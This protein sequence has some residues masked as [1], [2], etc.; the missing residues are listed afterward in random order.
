[1]Q[2]RAN[3]RPP[4]E[5][6]PIVP[7]APDESAR[8]FAD[9]MAAPLRDARDP[10][11]GT[12]PASPSAPAGAADPAGS[13][14]HSG[15]AD[16][17]R[18]TLSSTAAP[19]DDEPIEVHSRSADL[20]AHPEGLLGQVLGERYELLRL[21]GRGGMGAV[22]LARHVS[23]DAEYAVK[24]LLQPRDPEGQR[25]FVSEA[26]L[27]SKVRHSNTVFISD[28]GVARGGL[29]YLVMEHIPGRSL[30]AEVRRRGRIERGEA[31]H[32]AIEVARGLQAIHDRGIVH[33]DMKPEKVPLERAGPLSIRSGAGS[34]ERSAASRLRAL[35]IGRLGAAAARL[36]RPRAAAKRS[37]RTVRYY[38]VTEALRGWLLL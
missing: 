7:D 5:T 20:R 11:S 14:S 16:S 24:V 38:V 31:L 18:A 2:V 1:M 21:L 15:R 33:R 4:L 36:V 34:P 9:T 12:T 10:R 19:A 25:R 23:L 6:S 27:A 35:R 30:A 37:A 13:A 28:F 8:A 29:L 3:L 17:E 22:Y 32:I 26:R